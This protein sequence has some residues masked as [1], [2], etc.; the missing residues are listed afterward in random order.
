MKLW[1][2]GDDIDKAFERFTVGDDRQLDSRLVK[3]D[4][5]ASRAHAR[6][7]KSIGLLTKSE[8]EDIVRELENMLLLV[9]DGQFE[10]R[11]TS[12]DCHSEI[13]LRLIEKLGETGKKIHSGRSRNDQVLV[14]LKLYAK[15][16][17][18]TIADLMEE[19]FDL[20]LEKS[21]QNKGVLMPGYTHMQ[22]AMPSSF[23]LWFGA[24]AESLSDDMLF[25]RAAYELA[26]KNPLGSAAG[27]GAS[28]PL[29]REMT[30]RDLG[31][32]R[33]DVNSVYAQSTRGRLEKSVAL[34]ISMV[35]GTV[36]RFANDVCTYS[37]QNFGFFS[38]DNSFTTGSS[39]MPHKNNP[40]GFELVRSHANQL[41]FL[42]SEI[43]SLLINLPTGYHR[44]LQLLKGSFMRGIERLIEILK[45]TVSMTKVLEVNDQVIDDPR[46]D[47]LFTVE[48]VNKRVIEGVPFRDAYKQV[49]KEVREGSFNATRTVDHKHIGSI[50][51]LRNDL[52]SE[53]FEERIKFFAT[54]L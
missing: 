8:S 47:L 18:R 37:G 50:G 5:L 35:A 3:Y 12:E 2:K 51:N 32:S 45:I 38:L 4:L 33:L 44:D 40:D 30:A 29:D 34:S 13:E 54:G 7:L 9:E 19:F 11:E 26:D 27:Y 23:G 42:P 20:L 43:N 24:Y 48:D 36:S 31:F 49:A 22:V 41:Q 17:L 46:Y 25:L 16:H 28:F 21:E 39:I 10:I 14:A 1:Q 6:M 52:I 15:D 53:S